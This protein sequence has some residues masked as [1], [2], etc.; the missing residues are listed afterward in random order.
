L[1][2]KSGS[3]IRNRKVAER[4]QEVDADEIELGFEIRQGPLRHLRQ[5]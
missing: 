5:G 1:D 3:R 4:R 2:K